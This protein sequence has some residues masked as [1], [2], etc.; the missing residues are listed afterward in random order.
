[1]KT[2][3][4]VVAWVRHPLYHNWIKFLLLKIELDKSAIRVTVNVIR[5]TGD[6]TLKFLYQIYKRV[7]T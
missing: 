6:I 1:M 4:I 5:V 3:V 7:E 2:V